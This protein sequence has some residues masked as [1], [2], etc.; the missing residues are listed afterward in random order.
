M[1]VVIPVLIRPRV[2][3]SVCREEESRCFVTWKNIYK[4]INVW[5]Y[6]VIEWCGLKEP[7]IQSCSNCLPW[8]GTPSATRSCSKPHPTWL[9]AV[10]GLSG[11]PSEGWYKCTKNPEQS[12]NAL[13]LYLFRH[14]LKKYYA[15]PIVN[16][17]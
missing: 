1:C 12:P 17:Y 15:F 8:A 5:V 4:G 3:A 9:W 7:Q 2:S 6:K 11:Y 13:K 16:L 14:S 10:P